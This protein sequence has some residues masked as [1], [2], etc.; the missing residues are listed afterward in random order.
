MGQVR[1]GG[2]WCELAV[3]QGTR[4]CLSNWPASQ[5]LSEQL[6][7]HEKDMIEAALAEASG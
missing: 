3:A 7:T 5:P 4:V 6:V 1:R 2:F